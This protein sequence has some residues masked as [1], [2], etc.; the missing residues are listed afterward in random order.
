M[1]K[2][3][4]LILFVIVTAVVGVLFYTLS[5]PV[6]RGAVL[7]VQCGPVTNVL[8]KRQGETFMVKVTFRNT[9]D[10]S[11][12]WSV[13]VAFEG[14]SNWSWRGT[15]QTLV[16]KSSKTATLTW[17]SQVPENAEVGSTARLIVYFD[18]DFAP[19]NWWI[20]IMP[21]AEL[22]IVSSEVS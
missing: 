13:N 15:A 19:Q 7:N 4:Y 21:G 2:T 8:D 12:S 11:G 14:E 3:Y 22:R 6:I 20:R 10:V 17:T 16:L 5:T 18:D 9:G 1:R